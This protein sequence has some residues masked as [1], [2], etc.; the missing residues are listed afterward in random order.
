MDTPVLE[1]HH[2]PQRAQLQAPELSAVPNHQGG[3]R[4]AGTSRRGRRDW[5]GQGARAAAAA[6]GCCCGVRRTAGWGLGGEAGRASAAPRGT[7]ASMRWF[8]RTMAM[9]SPESA[10]RSPS[11]NTRWAASARASTSCH[12][13]ASSM[14]TRHTGG[15]QQAPLPAAPAA[16]GTGTGF[17]A[18]GF[19]LRLVSARACPRLALLSPAPHHTAALRTG[20][21]R[22][23]ETASRLRVKRWIRW[24]TAPAE[25][26]P[27]T[28]V[29]AGV[30]GAIS[31][32]ACA[33]HA[34]VR[35]LGL[36][37][38]LLGAC[39]GA[40]GLRGTCCR[41]RPEL[42]VRG[43]AAVGS[44]RRACSTASMAQLADDAVV[45]LVLDFLRLVAPLSHHPTPPPPPPLPNHPTLPHA[46][47]HACPNPPP[48]TSDLH[49][50]CAR[51]IPSVRTT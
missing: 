6:V 48:L 45:G 2:P 42:P 20:R 50:C 27:L 17:N 12:W 5:S 13:P 14:R 32:R 47:P 33:P 51:A 21:P 9:G 3:G 43:V 29:W 31:T 23:Y 19:C 49:L 37:V 15:G 39:G 36:L 38:C 24:V 40:A 11:S 34:Q 1:Q 7:A 26:L 16:S 46:C 10:Q 22:E 41:R 30:V 35:R 25:G 4:E 8:P 18:Q 44:A 28:A